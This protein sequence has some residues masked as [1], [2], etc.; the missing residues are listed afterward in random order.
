M[1]ELPEVETTLRGLKPHIQHQK[2]KTIV[3]RQY[4]LRWPIPENLPR[5]LSGQT[6]TNIERRGKY[7]LFKMP[8][9]TLIIHLGMSGSL[10]ILTTP[11]PPAKHDHVDIEFTNHI[12][13]RYTDPRRFGALLWA[14]D[15]LNT[16]PLIGK[17][18]VEPLTSAFSGHYLWQQAQQRKI[19]IK[20]LIMENKTVV[21]V[22]NIYATEALFSAKIYPGTPANVLSEIQITQL[23][24][25]IKTI[26]EEAIEQ[27]GTTLKDFVNSEGKPGYFFLKL[28]V[29]GRKNLPCVFCSEPIQVIT[30]G[31]R[32]TAFCKQCQPI[33][34]K[35]TLTT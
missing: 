2:I 32:T 21:G 14:P 13:L 19:P 31:Q 30:I 3:I 20:T 29:Y 9:G 8:A 5:L 15:D 25:A 16:H 18:G 34:G 6:I 24:H 33:K 23:V 17:L 11:I 4:K 27:G 12:I 7:L 35:Y 10:R 1:P 26:L 22:G 28:K